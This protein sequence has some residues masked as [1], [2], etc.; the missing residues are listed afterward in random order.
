MPPSSAFAEA[1]SGQFCELLPPPALYL[2]RHLRLSQST[3][4]SPMNYACQRQYSV[5]KDTRLVALFT[6]SAQA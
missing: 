6:N 4:T 2:L 5:Q 1:C 3:Y